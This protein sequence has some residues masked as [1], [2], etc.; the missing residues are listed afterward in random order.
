MINILEYFSYK[1]KSFAVLSAALHAGIKS[2]VYS[3]ID[4]V[5]FQARPYIKYNIILY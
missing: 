5:V 1:Q 3:I 4:S 2:I